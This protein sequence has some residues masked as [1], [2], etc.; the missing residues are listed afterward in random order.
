MSKGRIR[1]AEKEAYWRGQMGQQ[2]SSGDSVRAYCLDHGVSQALFF[3]WRREI[4]LR[5]ADR[6][7]SHHRS[8]KNGSHPLTNSGRRLA[9]AGAVAISPRLPG[10]YSAGNRRAGLPDRS[11]VSTRIDGTGLVAVDLVY[12]TM[13]SP[14]A[15]AMLE[16]ACPGGAV[17]RVRENA[18][19]DI[20]EAVMLACQR[21]QRAT[22]EVGTAGREVPS[23]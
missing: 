20:L 14:V 2:A 18:S 9:T 3:S 1:S 11:G 12:D 23:C 4:R 21:V 6:N 19:A 13:P 10:K 22:G 7:Q 17:I 16:I 15:N 5:D 8:L